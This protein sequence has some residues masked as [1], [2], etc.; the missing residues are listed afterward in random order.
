[1]LKHSKALLKNFI[2]ELKPSKRK[3]NTAFVY[4]IYDHNFNSGK[5]EGFLYVAT[6]YKAVKIL[7]KDYEAVNMIQEGLKI[8]FQKAEDMEAPKQGKILSGYYKRPR[9][10]QGGFQEVKPEALPDI[11]VIKAFFLHE[12]ALIK[13]KD[14]RLIQIDNQ[15]QFLRIFVSSEEGA[16][17]VK[18]Y[19]MN[20]I[21]EGVDMHY[22]QLYGKKESALHRPMVLK[23]ESEEAPAYII[24]PVRYHQ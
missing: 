20:A 12:E 11:K 9:D 18:H 14:T 5:E 3:D 16:P 22:F 24:T 17:E 1:M 7:L 19:I 6:V 15:Q 2:K 8:P 23:E 10:G 4:V 13:L 21:F